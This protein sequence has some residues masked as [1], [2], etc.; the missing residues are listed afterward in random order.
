MWIMLKSWVKGGLWSAQNCFRQE[1]LCRTT[2][3]ENWAKA[4]IFHLAFHSGS[5]K[6]LGMLDT[7]SK[8]QQNVLVKSTH[9]ISQK[10]QKLTPLQKNIH[11]DFCIQIGA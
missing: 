10:P 7:M 6:Y 1:N 9:K 5:K 11:E 2:D 4:A 8:S 3:F